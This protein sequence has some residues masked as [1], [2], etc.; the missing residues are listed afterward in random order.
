M[1]LKKE[2]ERVQQL[3]LKVKEISEKADKEKQEHIKQ[4]QQKEKEVEI[5][6]KEEV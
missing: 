2:R 5:K 6:V 4:L 1:E 3:E